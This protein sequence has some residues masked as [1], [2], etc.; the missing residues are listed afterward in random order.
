MRTRTPRAVRTCKSFGRQRAV[1]GLA[2]E[3][4]HLQIACM[5]IQYVHIDR[6]RDRCYMFV[7]TRC[8]HAE[9]VRVGRAPTYLPMQ[10]LR[11]DGSKSAYVRTCAC[12]WSICAG[13]YVYCIVLKARKP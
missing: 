13:L 2:M 6:D 3:V 9:F 4:P 1:Y 7:R 8:A 10:E 12:N 5:H 11:I